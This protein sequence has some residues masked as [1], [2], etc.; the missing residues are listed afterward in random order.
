MQQTGENLLEE[1]FVEVTDEQLASLKTGHQ[2][3]DSVMVSSNI[4]QMTRLHLLVEVVQRVW[5]MLTEADQAHYVVFEPYRQG[6]AGQYC[7][8]VKAEEVAEH[9]TALGQV[10]HRLV[11][12]LEGATETSRR[13]G[14]CSGF[15]ASILPW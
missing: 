1:V 7:Y 3:M 8:R 11:E 2:R 10:M 14:I 9:L 15:L 4:R 12:E 5:R 13:I 6:T